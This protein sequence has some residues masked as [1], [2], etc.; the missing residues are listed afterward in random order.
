MNTLVFKLVAT[1]LLI[2]AASLAGRRWGPNVGGWLVGLPLTSGPIAFFLALEQGASF[3]RGAAA[4]SLAGAAAEA[5]FC[6]AYGWLAARVRWPLAL[7]AGS[8]AFAVAAAM[9]ELAGFSLLPLLALVLFALVLAL[10]LM[11][12][13]I[14]APAVVPPRWWDIPARM[15]V[16]TIVVVGLTA[17]APRVGA[18]LSGLIATYPLFA[19]VLA[20]FGHH[21]QG[22]AAAQRVLSGLLLGLFSFAGFFFVLAMAIEGSGIIIAFSAAI[23]I[24]MAIQGASLWMLRRR[25]VARSRAR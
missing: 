9:L 23:A 22:A 17:A 1:P 19:A 13:P 16:A 20:V 2:Q 25:F 21:M 3:A 24:A 14:A 5:C 4:G 11:P 10:R 6:L 7:A 15:A 18:S 8:A 12:R